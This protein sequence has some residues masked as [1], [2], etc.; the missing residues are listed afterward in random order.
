[1]PGENEDDRF[2]Q[3]T[4]NPAKH[5]ANDIKR[6]WN[7]LGPNSGLALSTQLRAL[8]RDSLQ[9]QRG[10]QTRAACLIRQNWGENLGKEEDVVVDEEEGARGM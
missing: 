6:S 3:S 4:I 5:L 10:K 2:A 9:H 7:N 8:L 1:M